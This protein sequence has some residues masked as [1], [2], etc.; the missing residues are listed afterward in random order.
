MRR[1]MPMALR[2][3]LVSLIRGKCPS[4]RWDCVPSPLKVVYNL[5]FPS[6]HPV[7]FTFWFIRR[8]S[9]SSFSL[10]QVHFLVS[11]HCSHSFRSSL[12]IFVPLYISTPFDLVNMKFLTLLTFAVSASA[13]A[14]QP[15]HHQGKTK[16]NGKN[17][18]GGNRN[19]NAA[20]ISSTAVAAAP[21]ATDAATTG[22]ATTGGATTVA[23]GQTVV[24]FEVNGVPGNECMTFRNNGK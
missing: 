17:R 18:N 12:L 2:P 23:S 16:G 3:F 5:S 8:S 9:A 14:V 15:R 20:A 19:G 22:G 4:T 1:H 7:E 24:L 13:L 21:V 11:I 10:W 6:D